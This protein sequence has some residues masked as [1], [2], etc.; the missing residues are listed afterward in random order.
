[1]KQRTR[2][3]HLGLFWHE[4]RPYVA[5]FKA[6][7]LHFRRWHGH[8]SASFTLGELLALA[9]GQALLPGVMNPAPR[10]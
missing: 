9:T 1:M 4:G 8:K 10:L 3:A 2:A 7:R 6:G 5:T